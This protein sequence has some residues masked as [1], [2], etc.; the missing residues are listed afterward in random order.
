MAHDPADQKPRRCKYCRED[1]AVRVEGWR[2]G[3]PDA[4]SESPEMP[5]LS[6][7]TCA[8]HLSTAKLR[9]ASAGL[10]QTEMDIGTWI[11]GVGFVMERR[12]L[13]R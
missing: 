2:H 5:T 1:A 11:A 9:V 13:V 12:R 8:L 7:D 4:E 10:I 6:I 3:P